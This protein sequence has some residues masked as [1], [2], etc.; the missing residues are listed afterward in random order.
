VRKGREGGIHEG[1]ARPE[2][3]E[4]SSGKKP[5]GA[6]KTKRKKRYNRKR[7][8]E[9]HQKGR[10]EMRGVTRM[11]DPNFMPKGDELSA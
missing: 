4:Y 5:E 6:V 8:K 11:H 7:E 10:R 1:P 2:R 9:E 3:R